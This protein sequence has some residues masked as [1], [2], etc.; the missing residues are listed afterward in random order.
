MNRPQMREYPDWANTYISKVEE[1]VMEVLENQATAFPN[2]INS[3]AEKGDYAYAPGKWIIKELIGHIID[4]ERILVYR[5]LSFARGEK[6]SLPGFEEDDY[7]ASAHFKDRSMFSFS[8][9]FTLLRKANLFLIKSLTEREL[10]IIG[11]AS[12]RQISVR[13]IVW[14]LAGHIIHHKQIIKERY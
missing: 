11:M 12:E 13:A 1:N 7:V 6:A 3:L 14:V 9:E 10:D 5:M 4:T 2:L 8:E